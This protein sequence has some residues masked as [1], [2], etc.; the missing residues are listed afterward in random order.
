MYILVEGNECAIITVIGDRNQ[1][2]LWDSGAGRCVISYD[3]YN[4]LHPKFKTELFPSS[5]KIRAANGTFI[6]D[7]RECDV[8]FKINKERFTFPFLCLDQL[9]QQMILGHNFSKA[10]CIG[11]LWNAD[12]VMSLTRNGMPFAEMLPTHVINALVFCMESTVLPPYSNGYIKCKLPKAKGKLYIGKSCVFEPSFKH[13]S[14]Y[15]HCNT[16]EGLVTVD[17]TITGSGVFNM[18]MTSKSNRHIK[19]HSNQTMGM[20]CSCADSQICTIHEIVSFDRNPREG[21][22]THLIQT[23]QREIS[24]TFPQETLK[25]VDWM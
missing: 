14:Q 7:S 9:S 19:I 1:K 20:L 10:Y 18:V 5:V 13:R 12:D 2:A 8:T 17:D 22:M 21:G 24:T 23:P 6:P 15:S 25:G 4:S 3:F 11:M 16:Y